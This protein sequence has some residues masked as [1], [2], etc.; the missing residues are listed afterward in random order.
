MTRVRRRSCAARSEPIP[1]ASRW[2]RTVLTSRPTPAQT[3]R[4]LRAALGLDPDAHVS[5]CIGFVA[6]H[7]GF[8]RAVTAFGR[9]TSSVDV[10]DGDRRHAELHVVGSPSVGNPAAVR[11]AH[12]LASLAEATPGVTFHNAYVADTTFDRWLL[13]CDVVLLPYR[14]IWSSGR[15]RASRAVRPSGDRHRSGW[16]RRAARLQSRQSDHRRRRPR[17]RRRPGRGADRGRGAA[18]RPRRGG[19]WRLAV[20]GRASRTCSPRCAPGPNSSVASLSWRRMRR[21]ARDQARRHAGVGARRRFGEGSCGTSPPRSA[22]PSDPGV[23]TPGGDRRQATPAAPARLGARADHRLGRRAPPCH[24]GGRRGERDPGDR[25]ARR[26]SRQVAAGGQGRVPS[27]RPGRR[28]GRRSR[29][30]PPDRTRPRKA[31]R[32][33]PIGQGSSATAGVRATTA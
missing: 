30:G 15:R 21:P 20:L 32:R 31:E 3:A 33:P 16:P 29:R 23:G 26:R 10:V 5:L 27:R 6:E 22:R 4:P 25:Q 24:A 14:F 19:G 12:E 11:Y 1:P 18:R 17:V 7:K 8:D 13:A 9:A 2:W 28:S